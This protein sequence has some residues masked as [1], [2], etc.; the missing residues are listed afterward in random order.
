MGD[1]GQDPTCPDGPRGLDGDATLNSFNGRALRVK[2]LLLIRHAKSSWNDTTLSD[3][4]RPLNKR[5]KRD[6]PAMGMLLKNAQLSPDLMLS[7]PATRAHKTARKIA[8]AV[9][10]DPDRIVIREEIYLQG[11]SGLLD[12]LGGLDDTN[13]RIYLVGHN[14][15]LTELANQLTGAEIEYIPTCGIVSVEFDVDSWRDCVGTKGRVSLFVRPAKDK[16]DVAE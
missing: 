14:P 9:G 8:K 7:S 11:V 15:E 1:S 13:Q 3:R 6:A 4:D 2:N 12:V 5:G 10:Y 16:K